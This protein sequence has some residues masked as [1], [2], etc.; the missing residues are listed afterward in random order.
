MVEKLTLELTENEVQALH[1]LIE[2]IDYDYYLIGHILSKNLLF[3][4]GAGRGMKIEEMIDTLAKVQA[5][6]V[7]VMS[8]EDEE[9]EG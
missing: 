7:K 9:N 8:S 5:K 6:I 3:A 4:D 2:N 1:D